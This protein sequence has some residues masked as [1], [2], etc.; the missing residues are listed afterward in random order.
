M[1][2]ARNLTQEVTIDCCVCLICDF[3]CQPVDGSGT[4]NRIVNCLG[5]FSWRGIEA[6]DW[7]AVTSGTGSQ[8]V[9]GYWTVAVKC[10][11]CDA[12]TK[13]HGDSCQW[14]L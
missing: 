4:R 7:I 9:G 12:L 14:Q 13:G 11:G 8:L 10:G 1:G 3:P 5:Y 6:L 2:I